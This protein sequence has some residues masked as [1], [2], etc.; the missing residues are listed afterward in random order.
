MSGTGPVILVV[1]DDA[2]IRLLLAAFL[3]RQGYQLL[4]ACNGREAIA[5]MRTGKADVVV[6]DLMM[7]EVSGW[8]LLRMRAA[9]PSL[10]AIPVI[11]VTADDSPQVTDDLRDKHV[12]SILGKP[13]DLEAVSAAVTACLEPPRSPKRRPRN[14]IPSTRIA[15]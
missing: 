6:L 9:D 5:E 10:L 14:R 3:R 7:P 2:A 1:D 11:V 15:Q 8:D 4:Q 13:F 12:F